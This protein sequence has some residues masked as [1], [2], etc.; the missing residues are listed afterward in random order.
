[1]HLQMRVC[2]CKQHKGKRSIGGRHA[3]KKEREKR[4]GR[5]REREREKRRREKFLAGREKIALAAAVTMQNAERRFLGVAETWI[6]GRAESTVLAYCR[7]SFP[8]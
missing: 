7:F 4:G 6:W 1:M 8:P 3:R 5:E 2:V